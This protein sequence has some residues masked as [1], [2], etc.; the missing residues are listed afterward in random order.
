M[1]TNIRQELTVPVAGRISP[2][3]KTKIEAFM[4][5][6]GCTLDVALDHIIKASHPF[7]DEIWKTVDWSLSNGDIA[8]QFGFNVTYIAAKRKS[9]EGK[10]LSRKASKLANDAKRK[11]MWEGIDWSKRSQQIMKE[12]GKSASTVSIARRRYAPETMPKRSTIYV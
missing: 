2:Q 7:R 5:T 9:C 4:R 11:A 1:K 10:P 8:K 6:C 3:A 12:T